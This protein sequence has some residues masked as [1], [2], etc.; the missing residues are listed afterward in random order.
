[1]AEIPDSNTSVGSRIRQLRQDQGLS[2]EQLAV[3]AG[4]YSRTIRRIEQ[5]EDFTFGSLTAIAV[6][7]D[8]PLAELVDEVEGPGAA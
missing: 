3:K 4:L 5:G 8:L 2:Q 7:L 1:M 6:A